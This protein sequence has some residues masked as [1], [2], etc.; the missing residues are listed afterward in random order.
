MTAVQWLLT[1]PATGTRRKAQ[2]DKALREERENR[3]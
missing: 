2:L 1:E 3:A